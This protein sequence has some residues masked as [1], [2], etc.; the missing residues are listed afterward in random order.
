[1]ADPTSARTAVRASWVRGRQHR[2]PGGVPVAA[3]SRR[4]VGASKPRT[5]G[6]REGG[7]EPASRA[8]ARGRG[9][10][11][12]VL[13]RCEWG[14]TGSRLA[15]GE[16]W[17]G[18]KY[19][20]KVWLDSFGVAAGHT[21]H[22]KGGGQLGQAAQSKKRRSRRRPKDPG[23]SHVNDGSDVRASPSKAISCAGCRTNYV[24]AAH[25]SGF[26]SSLAASPCPAPRICPRL[27]GYSIGR[28]LRSSARRRL[29]GTRDDT[30]QK[31]G[32]SF[33]PATTP[34]LHMHPSHGYCSPSDARV[35]PPRLRI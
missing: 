23:K 27:D 21:T 3:T 6:G 1:M 10:G 14:E 34:H 33:S 26:A 18:V 16:W 25:R 29:L 11:S 15:D 22:G 2:A 13:G 35:S 19:R 20:A 24:S 31:I 12:D 28:C 32:G 8:E 4:R 30:M 5:V 9:R 7:V 17:R